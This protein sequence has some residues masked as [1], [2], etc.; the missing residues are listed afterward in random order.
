MTGSTYNSTS[1]NEGMK[2][3]LLLE[4]KGWSG[5]IF[6][7]KRKLIKKEVLLCQVLVAHAYNPSYSGGRDQEDQGSKR[8][9]ENSS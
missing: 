3:D 8:A 7:Y 2:T 6:N 4:A 5:D 9:R 1:Q